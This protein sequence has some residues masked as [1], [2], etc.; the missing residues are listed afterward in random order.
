MAGLYERD[1]VLKVAEVGDTIFIAQSTK[2]PFSRL[3]K[4]GKKPNQLLS[5][6]PVQNS[7]DRA[8]NGTMDGADVSAYTATNR[9]KLSAYG[10]LLRTA[11]WMVTKLATL[12]NT[13]GVAAR[14][15]KAKQ[16]ADDALIL[17]QMIEKQL[18]GDMDTQA[19]A[20]PSTPYQSRGAFEWLKTSAQAT[21]P[22]PAGYRPSSSAVFTS[23]LDGFDPDDLEG[24][25]EAMA[26]QKKG[27]VNLKLFAG[28]KLKRRM[29]LWAQR[30]PDVANYT[31]FPVNSTR[32]EDKKLSQVVDVFQF[33]A[34]Q[35][36]SIPSWYMLCDASTG[37]ITDYSSRS[38]LLVD[39][40]MWELCFLEAPG[41][42]ENPD[43]GGGPR[44][45]H[46]AT[47]ILKCLNPLGQGYVKTDSDS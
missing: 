44:G 25:L 43:L 23:A 30:Q 36:V 3:L 27:S 19:E 2:T 45:F 1:M 10:M 24:M 4:R 38:G 5:E 39:T 13:H 7:P 15:E 31:L 16:A 11:G 22:V 46:D 41:S 6:W 29:S 12:T 40:D 34:G 18:L 26:L 9:D 20:A 35:V 37:A 33:D 28:I 47:Y 42:Y 8:F 21:L 14:K 17:G 32:Q